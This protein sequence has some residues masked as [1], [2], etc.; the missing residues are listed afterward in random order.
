VRFFY[1]RRKNVTEANNDDLDALWPELDEV[2]NTP[3][4]DNGCNNLLTCEN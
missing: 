2:A 4:S 3:F 1:V